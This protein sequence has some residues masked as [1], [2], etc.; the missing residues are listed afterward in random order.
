MSE[1]ISFK[2]FITPTFIMI[3]YILGALVVTIGAIHKN[4]LQLLSCSI[5]LSVRFLTPQ[6]R[7]A[8]MNHLGARIAGTVVAFLGWLAFIVLYLA[9]YGG[10]FSFWQSLA[11]FIA[12]GAVVIAIIAVMWIY[13][14]LK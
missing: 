14:A 3:I 7:I 4:G 11:V 6:I 2:K 10:N 5:C 12:S 13:W 9:F 8:S 1:Y